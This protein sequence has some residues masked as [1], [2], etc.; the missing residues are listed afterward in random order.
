MQKK[1]S[2]RRYDRVKSRQPFWGFGD[3]GSQREEKGTITVGDD[4]RE[5]QARV[6]SLPFLSVK[7]R[8]HAAL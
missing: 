4:G 3:E 8:S 2:R 5:T 7:F 6:F 1:F